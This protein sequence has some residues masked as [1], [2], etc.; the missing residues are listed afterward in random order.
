MSPAKVRVFND[1]HDEG[2]A[3]AL[4]VDPD[5]GDS[6]YLRVIHPQGG[7][8]VISVRLGPKGGID[9]TRGVKLQ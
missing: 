9:I 2:T 6:F 5:A 4:E 1:F 8:R 3:V 7:S